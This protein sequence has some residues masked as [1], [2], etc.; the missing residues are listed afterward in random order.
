MAKKKKNKEMD[1]FIQVPE[2]LSLE[3]SVQESEESNQEYSVDEEAPVSSPILGNLE[4]DN[5]IIS[6][7]AYFFLKKMPSNYFTGMSRYTNVKIKRTFAAWEKI[8]STY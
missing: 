3:E 4:D 7:K 5:K 2:A 6:F 8:F 1:A